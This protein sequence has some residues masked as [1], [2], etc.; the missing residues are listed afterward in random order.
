MADPKM[1]HGFI[2]GAS[3]IVVL[4]IVSVFGLTSLN[5]SFINPSDSGQTISLFALSTI[6]FLGL[7]IFGFI[8]FRSLLKLYLERR[9][10]QLGSK[11]KTKLVCGALGLSLLPV[12][13][14]F[15]FSY[16]LINRTLDKW[17]S[18]P[19][20]TMSQDTG[21]IVEVLGGYARNN[22]L[23]NAESLTLGLNAVPSSHEGALAE[24]RK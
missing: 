6:I 13:F 3:V 22:A 12:C 2:I 9:A 14:L 17:F 24:L 5:L 23:A 20:E 19:Y 4:L 10:K 21:K 15:L 16:S 1:R 18:R 7:V 8:L 11:F